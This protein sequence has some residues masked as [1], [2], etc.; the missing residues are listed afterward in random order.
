LAIGPRTSNE[1]S[2]LNS[3]SGHIPYT[4][5]VEGKTIRLPYLCTCRTILRFSSKSSSKTDS[6]RSTYT[7]GVAIATSG[8]ITSAFLMWYSIHSLLIEMSPSTKSN[9]GCFADL[10]SRSADRSIP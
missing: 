4:S 9:R 2:S 5:E 8:R 10:P 7:F 3:L 1:F 6:G